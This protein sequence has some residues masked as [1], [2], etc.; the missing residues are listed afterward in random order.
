MG[1]GCRGVTWQVE[2][3]EHVTPAFLRPGCGPEIRKG[4]NED[5]DKKN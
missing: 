5:F 4:V 3:V 2:Y 1:P